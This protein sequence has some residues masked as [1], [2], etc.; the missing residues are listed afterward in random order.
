MT[1]FIKVILAIG[2]AVA[3]G[4]IGLRML[5]YLTVSFLAG[6][7]AVAMNRAF[8]GDLSGQFQTVTSEQN[9]RVISFMIL[10]VIPLISIGYLGRR[11]IV[12][13]NVDEDI[14]DTVNAVLG[15]GYALAIYVTV[16]YII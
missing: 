12:L 5:L 13:L 8:F 11:L 9:S 16:L 2:V 3:G 1:G 10:A 7:A 14:S 15:S 4:R 6:F